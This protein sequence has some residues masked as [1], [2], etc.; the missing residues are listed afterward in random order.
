[1]IADICK[2][3]IVK[4]AKQFLR[5]RGGSI[6]ISMGLAMLPVFAATGIAI[7]AVRLSREQAAFQSA[8]DSAALALGADE[9]ALTD[10]LRGAALAERIA[11]L[12]TLATK[13]VNANFAREAGS[14]NTL[15]VKVEVDAKIVRLKAA[16]VFDPIFM[17]YAGS[18]GFELGF[19]SEVKKPGRPTELVMVVDTTGSMDKDMEGLKS[20]AKKLLA[21]LYGDQGSNKP[22]ASEF[23]RVALVPFSAAVRLDTNA[24]DYDPGWIDRTGANPLSRIN[25]T[26]PAGT[27][28]N[29]NFGMWGQLRRT[30]GTAHEWNG[31]VESR[32]RTGA[33]GRNYIAEDIAPDATDNQSRF[34]AFFNPDS[35]TFYFNTVDNPQRHRFMPASAIGTS[36]VGYKNLNNNYITSFYD[37]TTGASQPSLLAGGTRATGHDDSALGNNVLSAEARFKN[38]AK[39]VNKVLADETFTSQTLTY[40]QTSD[41]PFPGCTVTP[42]NNCLSRTVDYQKWSVNAGPWSSCTA[43]KVVPMTY[44][45]SKIEAGIDAMRAVGGTNITEGLAWGMRAISPG[46]PFTRV[47]GYTHPTNPSLNLASTT[48]APYTGSRWRKVVVLMSDGE[49]SAYQLFPDGTPANLFDT[50]TGYNSYG[51]I[52]TVGALNRYGTDQFVQAPTQMD[53]DTLAMC[54]TLKLQDVELYTI[55]FKVDSELL[56]DCAS[57]EEHYKRAN[58]VSELEKFFNDIGAETRNKMLYV[59]K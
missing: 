18:E 55:G 43:S 59:S 24:F 28:A 46:A 14:P 45:R 36:T 27:T 58:T 5:N 51:H 4:R 10:H 38:P 23:I 12:E 30:N 7:D 19:V 21:A 16:H 20:A 33:A 57:D 9:R 8:V 22:A 42:S 40:T 25:F 35:P 6:S 39:Y 29:H 54:N 50:S 56:E 1:M 3:G 2:T 52:R 11:L 53:A 48:I 26:N 37:Y 32:I 49:N 31:C 17:K 34:P 13:F 44:T 15:R 47:E 41:T